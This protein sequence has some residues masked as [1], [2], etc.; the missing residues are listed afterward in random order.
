MGRERGKIQYRERWAQG[1]DFSGLRFLNITPTDVDV[2]VEFGD[3]I[4]I[5]GEIKTGDTPLSMGQETA[6]T[7][8]TD[9]I[10]ETGRQS[11]F[12]VARHNTPVWQ[13]VDV[14]A[15]IV[16]RI[17]FN[18]AWYPGK[19]ATVY[20]IISRFLAQYYDM[21]SQGARH[22]AN[23]GRVDTLPGDEMDTPSR[24]I[25]AATPQAQEGGE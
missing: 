12:F 24:A 20:E 3:K 14:S 17:R 5:V 18:Q 16:E 21:P 1:R 9:A 15:A 25:Q 7:R 4:F 8:L 23:S 13:D 2:L 10:A 6:L 11:M 22:G 19:G